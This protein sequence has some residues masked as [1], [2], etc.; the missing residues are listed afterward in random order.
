MAAA[1]EQ[2]LK[3]IGGK[4]TDRVIAIGTFQ[5]NKKK[6]KDFASTLRDHL[7]SKLTGAKLAAV[8]DRSAADEAM[9]ELVFGD[10]I[11]GS[12]A[13]ELGK[14]LKADEVV[15]GKIASMGGTKV[16]ARR[17]PQRS[18]LLLE[19]GRK[20]LRARRAQGESELLRS[21]L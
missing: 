19:V 10:S 7:A 15:Y 8:V 12:Q 9:D 17:R 20:R 13:I 2:A 21:P 5:T 18:L 4:V 14:I 6:L 3:S 1:A 16:T 11:S